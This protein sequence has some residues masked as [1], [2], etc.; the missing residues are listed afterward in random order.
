MCLSVGEG[1]WGGNNAHTS[2]SYVEVMYIYCSNPQLWQI[3]CDAFDFS[4]LHILSI[5]LW[6]LNCFRLRHIHLPLV[7]FTGIFFQL[8]T[9]TTSTSMNMMLSQP[10]VRWLISFNYPLH[11]VCS[12]LKFVKLF[13]FIQFKYLFW[14]KWKKYEC[15]IKIS[16]N[17]YFLH[18]LI[19]HVNNRNGPRV[20]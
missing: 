2:S 15:T 14:G 17:V 19:V 9:S 13:C 4:K 8:K 6:R 7:D 10:V 5:F 12:P 1:K 18:N 16:E 11:S 3:H 20:L